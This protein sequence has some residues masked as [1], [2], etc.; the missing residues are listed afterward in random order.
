MK[1]GRV[2]KEFVQQAISELGI[3]PEKRNPLNS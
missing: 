2:S 3:D 1:E